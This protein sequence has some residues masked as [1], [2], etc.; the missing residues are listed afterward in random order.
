MRKHQVRM[1]TLSLLIFTVAIVSTI[2]NVAA[3]TTYRTYHNA[4]FDYSISYPVKLLI[5]QGEPVNGDG[6]RFTSRDGRAEMLVYGSHNSLDKTLR[7]V[8]DEEISHPEHP[9][10][11][12]TYQVFRG[13]WFVMSGTE[14]G[15]VFYQKTMLRNGVFKTFRIEYDRSEK[16]TYDAITATIS[17]SFNG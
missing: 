4:R 6:Q 16:R 1:A 9:D 14:N 7:Q 2:A 17:R 5:P 13:D 15:R 8:Y 12:V 10:R 3:Q 11:T